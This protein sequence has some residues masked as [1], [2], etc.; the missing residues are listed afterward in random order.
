MCKLSFCFL[1][2]RQFRCC[3]KMIS[4]MEIRDALP[5][6][7]VGELSKK[8]FYDEEART[9]PKMER[10]E[11]LKNPHTDHDRHS[12]CAAFWDASSSLRP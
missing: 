1:Q 7:A 8:E 6:T 2:E 5:R 12:S 9:Q 10:P 3:H 4:A 11:R